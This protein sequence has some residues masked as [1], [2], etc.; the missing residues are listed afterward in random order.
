MSRADRIMAETSWDFPTAD[1]D[2][3][4]AGILTSYRIHRA[5]WGDERL[6]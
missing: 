3:S 1:S 5:S 2:I 6:A 4:H